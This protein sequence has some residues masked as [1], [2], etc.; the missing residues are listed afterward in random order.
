MSPGKQLDSIHKLE[1]IGS[2]LTAT[3]IRNN[4]WSDISGVYTTGQPVVQNDSFGNDEAARPT[5]AVPG[6]FTYFYASGKRPTS[7]DYQPRTI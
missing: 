3:A 7:G 5:M 1:T 4:Q 6:E 2:R